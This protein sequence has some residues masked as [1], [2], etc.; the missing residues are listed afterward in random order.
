MPQKNRNFRKSKSSNRSQ[1]R[2]L[3]LGMPLL[4]V[5][6]SNSAQGA[7][8]TWSNAAGGLWSTG[9]NWSTNNPPLSGDD[10]TNPL[11]ATITFGTTASVDSFNTAG[12]FTFSSGTLTGTKAAA[13]APITLTGLFTWS[14]GTLT[15]ATTVANGGIDFH[16]TSD[17]FLSGGSL[18]NPSGQSSTIGATGG[19]FLELGSGATFTNAGTLTGSGGAE[20]VNNGGATNTFA[21]NGT[22]DVTGS[23]SVET[24]LVFTNTGAVNVQSGTLLLNA[25]DNATTTGTFAVSSGATLNFGNS[26]TLPASSVTGAG[27][28]IFSGGTTSVAG[29]FSLGNATFSG[30]SVNINGAYAVS[31]TTTF[32]G[33]SVN[34]NSTITNFGT[35]ALVAPS[36]N[37]NFGSNSLTFPSITLSGVRSSP[38]AHSLPPVFSPS[39]AARSLP[40]PPPPTAASIFMVRPM[41]S[42]PADR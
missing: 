5:T 28:V 29:P 39:P 6:F 42:F 3:A 40:R 14:T 21:N 23:F 22:F 1:Y 41:Y 37:I 13:A 19:V 16:G 32:S 15:T 4:M 31:G 7:T 18:T 27:N 25:G 20:I 10:A 38:R 17:V 24:G 26:Y 35:N 2:R 34:F 36:G 30:G 8:D 33:G 9:T 12:A 11:N